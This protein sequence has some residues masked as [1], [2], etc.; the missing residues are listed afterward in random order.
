MHNWLEQQWLATVLPCAEGAPST[1]RTPESVPEAEPQAESCGPG[2]IYRLETTLLKVCLRPVTYFIVASG[3]VGP[4]LHK[5]G[6][7]A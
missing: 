2:Q 6:D 7:G 3:H 1:L 4:L 5:A